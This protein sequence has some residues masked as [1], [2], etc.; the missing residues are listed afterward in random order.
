MTPTQH[1]PEEII[2]GKE[3]MIESKNTMGHFTTAT[4]DEVVGEVAHLLPNEEHPEFMNATRPLK[5]IYVID[6]GIINSFKGS[7]VRWK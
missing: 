3:V 1:S 6:R 7:R 2:K 4:V 5:E